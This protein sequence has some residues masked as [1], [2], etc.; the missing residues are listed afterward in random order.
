MDKPQN[1][2]RTDWTVKEL[3]ER[4]GLNPS[5][6][7]QLLLAGEIKGYKRGPSWLVLN[8]EAQRWLENRRG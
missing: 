8:A 3:A 2:G 1:P 7:R 6:I 4:A 5:R